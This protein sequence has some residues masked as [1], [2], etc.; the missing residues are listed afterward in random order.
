MADELLG[1]AVIEI[2]AS[3][4]KLTKD[5]DRAK[6]LTAK[7]PDA[8][9]DV[10]AAVERAKA[11]L[12]SVAKQVDGLPDS[13]TVKIGAET[14]GALG[15]VRGLDRALGAVEDE[16]VVV[17]ADTTRATGAL[18]SLAGTLA[19][20]GLGRAALGWSK[21]FSAFEDQ[22]SG[23]SS[24]LGLSMDA[25]AERA[26]SFEIVPPTVAATGIKDLAN[27]ASGYGIAGDAG[28]QWAAA[29]V[30]VAQSASAVLGLPVEEV[31]NGIAS[32]YRGEYDSLQRLIPGINGAAVEQRALAMAGKA[33]AAE[34]TE[35]ERAAAVNAI[36]ME[37][38]AQLAAQYAA[39]KD[40]QAFAE[41]RSTAEQEKATIVAGEKLNP[42]M[43]SL[44]NRIADVAGAFAM[45]PGPVQTGI[46]ALV[47]IGIVA[48]PI[49]T[50]VNLPGEGGLIGAGGR[51]LGFV[52]G[53]MVPGLLTGFSFLMAHPVFLVI[54]AAVLALVGIGYLLWKNWDTIV[55]AVSAGWDLLGEKVNAVGDWIEG[56]VE[57][58][59]GFLAE[60]WAWI[61]EKAAA[62]ADWIRDKWA[63]LVGFITGIPNRVGGALGGVFDT[64]VDGFKRAW[65]AMASVVNRADFTL[66]AAIPII[67]G[68]TIGLPD[69]PMLASGGSIS[70]SG[71]AI[72]GER[73]PEVR[74][75]N[76]GE[77]ISPI[78]D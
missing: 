68:R 37:R 7:L 47:G 5:L 26:R 48:G 36:V 25:I 28:L 30:D 51:L 75:L 3:F 17:N 42:A 50:V 44:Q 64:V 61:G 67:G 18:K 19:S 13:E 16:T 20:V 34:L 31:V 49:S 60:K 41:R 78:S 32:A 39:N 52:R 69:L 56:R 14:E 11:E 1:S 29:Q 46:L 43:E 71:Y 9:V 40:T 12:A 57:A 2:R 77:A 35:A 22:V 8:T 76:R 66:P 62:A 74:W 59:A 33:T 73:G 65:N 21:D 70:R 24:L 58:V 55:A 72:V 45:L 15:E 6:Q 23:A 63:G 54:G 10:D 27:I 4:E 38:G 53:T